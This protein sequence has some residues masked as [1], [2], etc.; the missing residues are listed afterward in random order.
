[1]LIYEKSMNNRALLS[2]YEIKIKKA[3]DH[4]EYSHKKILNLKTQNLDEEALETWESYTSRLARVV[5]IF[6]TKYL[7]LRVLN[8]DPAFDGTLREFC[9]YG[10]KMNLLDSTD[11]WLVLRELRNETAH[12]YEDA[13]LAEFFNRLRSEAP[14]VLKLR[15]VFK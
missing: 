9:N 8:E 1:M 12:E 13:D 15:D 14:R 3:L 4:L 11:A 6:L 5:D 7:K 2:S 10:E